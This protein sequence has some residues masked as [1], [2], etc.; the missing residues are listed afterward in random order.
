M[1]WAEIGTGPYGH[2]DQPP[3]PSPGLT[4]RAVMAKSVAGMTVDKVYD[5]D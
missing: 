5:P 2:A 4:T 3:A 1:T